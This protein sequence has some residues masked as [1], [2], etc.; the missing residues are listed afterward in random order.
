VQGSLSKFVRNDDYDAKV[1]SISAPVRGCMRVI[2]G[3]NTLSTRYR[4]M[5]CRLRT[6]RIG[7]YLLGSS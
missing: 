5:G 6:M 1:T 3:G 4:W 7:F 2:V